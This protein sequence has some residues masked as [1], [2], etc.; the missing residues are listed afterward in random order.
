MTLNPASQ[1]GHFSSLWPGLG[2]ILNFLSQP[3]HSISTLTIF[4]FRINT[5][6][7]PPQGKSIGLSSVPAIRIILQCGQGTFSSL[8]ASS[9]G[10]CETLF[11][12]VQTSHSISPNPCGSICAQCAHSA[13]G[14]A[15][16]DSTSA[17]ASAGT[18]LL[19]S[20]RRFGSQ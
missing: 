11:M 2:R 8:I 7:Q 3:G 18:L 6:E 13:N 12:A 1:A 16:F 10:W 15:C 4:G 20:G 14:A 17:M 19:S 9:V 5:P